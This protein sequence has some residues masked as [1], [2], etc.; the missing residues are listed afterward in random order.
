MKKITLVF[1]IIILSLSGTSLFAG[2]GATAVVDAVV[3]ANLSLTT[4]DSV[5]F[6]TLQ[7]TSTPILNPIGSG[8][9]DIFSGSTIGSFDL[10]GANGQTVVV[11]EGG[12]VTLGDG[13]SNTMTFT[14]NLIGFATDVQA[15]GT[16]VGATVV[17]D[18]SAGTYFF[19]LGG[20]L[21]TLTNKPAGSYSSD[22]S[23]GTGNWTL[24]VEYQ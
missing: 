15:S 10:T 23:N 21:G 4:V 17:L 3:Q 1:A 16:P 20:D 22:A 6:G 2:D 24:D 7:P 12:P 19:W 13:G 11:T 5:N 14:P 8:H 9:T 18:G